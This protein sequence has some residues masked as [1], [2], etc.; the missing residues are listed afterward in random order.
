M[1]HICLVTFISFISYTKVHFIHFVIHF[2][3]IH[4]T[5]LSSFHPHLPYLVIFILH[6]YSISLSFFAFQPIL[7]L[8][9]D[10]ITTPFHFTR[11]TTAKKYLKD[12]ARN[13]HSHTH[14]HTHTHTYNENVESN[15]W[16][17]MDFICTWIFFHLQANK[18]RW[19]EV[20]QVHHLPFLNSK[21]EIDVIYFL[22]TWSIYS[23]NENTC[24]KKSKLFVVQYYNN[25]VTFFEN[26]LNSMN[27]RS[28]YWPIVYKKL[29]VMRCLI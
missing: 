3:L 16:F 7:S 8:N 23:V 15:F 10:G 14:K 17:Y 13:A 19:M 9:S 5:D 2:H 4:S 18:S 1:L 26:I 25:L 24:K 27:F 21:N 29:G 12:I 28:N 6:R 22:T 11:I 20:V